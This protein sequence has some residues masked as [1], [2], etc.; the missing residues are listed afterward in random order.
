MTPACFAVTDLQSIVLQ[1]R[2]RST[3]IPVPPTT[4]S[5]QRAIALHQQGHLQQAQILYEQVLRAQP[6][7]FDA[8]H[9]L[10]VIAGQTNDP[11]RAVELISRAVQINPD[12]AAAHCNR[13]SALK[14]IGQLDAALKSLDRAIAIS[15]EFSDAHSNRGSVLSEL[16]RL[17]AALASYDRAIALQ[18][19]N[20]GAH[21]NRGNLLRRLMRFEEAV[22]SYDRAIGLRPELANAHGFKAITLLLIGQLEQGWIEYEWRDRGELRP[23][24]APDRRY[25]QPRWNG[26][27]SVRGQTILLYSEQGLGDTIQFC[28]YARMVAELGARVLLEAPRPLVRLLARLEGVAEVVAAGDTVPAFDCHC[29]LMSLPLAFKTTL[30]TIPREVRYLGA[31]ASQIARWSARLGPRTKPRIGLVWSG[32]VLATQG[33]YRSLELGE[34][35]EHLPREFHYVGLQKELR[36]SDHPTLHKTPWI[37]NIGE[38]LDDFSDTAA[39]CESLD[40]VISVDTSVAHLSAALGRPTWVLLPYLPDWRWLLKRDDSPW[41]PSAKLYR[42]QSAGDWS[43]ALTRVGADLARLASSDWI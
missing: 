7:N 9:L 25:S 6:R 5:L 31:A 11:I 16:N 18:A 35:L 4:D 3:K 28:R 17:D 40:L 27:Q 12:S 30:D 20:A 22:A 23:Q 14:C 37:S 29:A 36:A 21:L 34:L 15:P 33:Y 43:H 1:N 24:A 39:V 38:Q 8:L 42:Q 2:D 13:G 32:N 19:N 10:G 26:E 41:Y